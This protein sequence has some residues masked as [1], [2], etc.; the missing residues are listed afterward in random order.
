MAKPDPYVG[1][2]ILAGQFKVLERI[3]AGGMGSVYKAHQPSMDRLVA[4]KIL[5]SKFTSRKDLS[6]IH[7]S[8]PTRPY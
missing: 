3:G 7:I 5:H 6:L 8:E 4:V 2:E 1:K